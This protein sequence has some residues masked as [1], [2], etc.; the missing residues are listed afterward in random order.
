[1]RPAAIHATV[2]AQGIAEQGEG[3]PET[4]PRG[5]G[6]RQGQGMVADELGGFGEA[7]VGR[8]PA[9]QQTRPVLQHQRDGLGVDLAQDPIGLAAAHRVELPVA[10]PEFEEQLD[11]PAGPGQHEGVGQAEPLG[12]HVSDED[13]PIF[14]GE[15]GLGNRLAAAFGLTPDPATAP[16][17]H[18]G[19]YPAG[20]QPGRQA[21]LDPQADRQID[22]WR[23]LRR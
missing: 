3:G 5:Q 2:G 12:R 8:L 17:G 20:Q 23:L 6:R 11:L 22:R 18:L 4:P 13:L 15:A 7:A 9:A 19:R 10:L 21:V 16:G 1:M 14:Q